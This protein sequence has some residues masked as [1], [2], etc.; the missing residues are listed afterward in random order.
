MIGFENGGGYFGNAYGE[1]AC[2][3][4]LSVNLSTNKAS[5]TQNYFSNSKWTTNT[6]WR[7]IKPQKYILD[8]LN[9]KTEEKILKN[10]YKIFELEWVN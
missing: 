7:N 2:G 8:N 1:G 6:K 9:G 4:C 3:I 5:Y 10:L